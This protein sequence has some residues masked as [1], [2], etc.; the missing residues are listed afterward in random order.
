MDNGPKYGFVSHSCSCIGSLFIGT[1]VSASIILISSV[2]VRIDS[3]QALISNYPLFCIGSPIIT[4]V[5][6]ATSYLMVF[7]P[8]QAFKLIK[9]IYQ[10]FWQAGKEFR[11]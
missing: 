9:W 6:W 11:D 7:T 8:S 1:V 3:F 4:A 2:I 5:L 10:D